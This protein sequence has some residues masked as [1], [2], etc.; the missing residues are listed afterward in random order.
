MSLSAQE[1]DISFITAHK[2]LKN[3]GKIS[4]ICNK[5]QII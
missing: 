1:R 3:R 4:K 5:I 2:S